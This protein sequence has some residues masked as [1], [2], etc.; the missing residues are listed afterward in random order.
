MALKILPEQGSP[1]LGLANLALRFLQFLF[2]A[3]VL[4][5][6][7]VVGTRTGGAVIPA[8]SGKYVRKLFSS[9]RIRI[10]TYTTCKL[11]IAFSGYLLRRTYLVVHHGC[12]FCP[13]TSLVWL[14]SSHTDLDLV[15]L[16]APLSSEL[17]LQQGLHPS[18]YMGRRLQLVQTNHQQQLSKADMDR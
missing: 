17:T 15:S 3:V 14:S 5:L 16:F 8:H 4:V 12:C 6:L 2:A 7:A 1:K 9:F 10:T 18:L 13:A 11:T